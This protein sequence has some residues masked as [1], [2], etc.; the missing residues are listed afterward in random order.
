MKARLLLYE[1]F[2]NYDGSIVEMK[3]WKVVKTSYYPLGVR[4]SLFWIKEG[5]ILVGYDNHFP[6]GP[7]RHYGE[8]EEE[9]EWVSVQ[10]L[11]ED[12]KNDLKR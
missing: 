3:V 10:K 7:H 4:Y 6:K 1:K 2:I 8:L 9:Y 5:K 11:I 12:F